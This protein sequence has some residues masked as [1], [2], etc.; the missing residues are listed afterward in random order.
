MVD[1][2]EMEE[3]MMNGKKTVTERKNSNLLLEFFIKNILI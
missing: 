1:Y 3:M 2:E